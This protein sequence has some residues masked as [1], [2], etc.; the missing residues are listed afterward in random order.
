[1]SKRSFGQAFGGR[2]QFSGRRKFFKPAK[3]GPI[4]RFVRRTSRRRNRLQLRNLVTAG[5]LG[6]EKKFYDTSLLNSALTSPTDSTTGAQNPSAT[7]CLNTVTQGDSESQRDGKQIAM[8][9]LTIKGKLSVDGLEDQIALQ[10]PHTI[11]VAVVLDTQTN[12]ALTATNNIFKNTAA[13]AGTSVIPLRNLLFGKR[14]RILK[15]KRFTID[16]HEMQHAANAIS[17]SYRHRF[18]DWFIPL[19]GMKV[20]YSNTTETI[21]N[22]IDNSISVIAYCTTTLPTISYNARLRF[23]G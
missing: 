10:S 3:A 11:F 17:S 13:N 21:A 18:F 23:V 1:M 9:N 20:N 12:G 22:I 2:R 16:N 7:I 19:K 5:F 15:Q 8:L 14:F 6:I 4:D